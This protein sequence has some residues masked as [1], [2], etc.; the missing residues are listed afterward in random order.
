[1]RPG[2]WCTGISFQIQWGKLAIHQLQDPVQGDTVQLTCN[3]TAILFYTTSAL[4]MPSNYLQLIKCIL[5]EW[6][7]CAIRLSWM[8]REKRRRRR[9]KKE[10]KKEEK[11]HNK[12]VQK[13]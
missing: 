7:L 2:A 6:L 1:M 5:M 9:E 11:H 8:E 4:F 10:R 12:C 13:F 3:S